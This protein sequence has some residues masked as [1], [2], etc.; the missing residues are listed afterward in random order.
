ML[1]G[2]PHATCTLSLSL[3]APTNTQDLGLQCRAPYVSLI[4]TCISILLTK[5]GG[6][7]T[8][9]SLQNIYSYEVS[10][11]LA[12]LAKV[13]SPAKDVPTQAFFFILVIN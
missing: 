13:F 1:S 2:V 4:Q 7:I 11:G 12:K 6:A 9:K 8:C 5:T 10:W 3:M